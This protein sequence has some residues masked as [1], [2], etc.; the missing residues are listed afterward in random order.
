VVITA[1][2]AS[3]MRLFI[4]TNRR[5]DSIL[6]TISKQIKFEGCMHAKSGIILKPRREYYK[7]AVTL[8][9][10]SATHIAMV[11]DR[12]LQDVWGAKRIGIKTVMVQKLGKI[13]WSDQLVTMHDRILFKI[14][15][16]KYERI[17][18]ER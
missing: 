18:S 4:A 17:P 2:Q 15:Q 1:L 12:L 13:V 8:S 6:K 7:Q 3:G 16:K 9:G 5:D 11:G 14:F 10:E